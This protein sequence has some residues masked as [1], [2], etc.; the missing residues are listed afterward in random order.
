MN[1]MMDFTTAAA[2]QE[3][4]IVNTTQSLVR[5]VTVNYNPELVKEAPDGMMVPGEESKVVSYV[6][7]FFEKEGIR[8]Q[9][10]G[11]YPR[12]DIVAVIGRGEEGRKKLILPTHSDV[13]PS[14]NGWT[15]TRNPFFPFVKDGYI[16]GRGTTDNKGQMAACMAMAR[17]LKPY[18][19]QIAGQVIFAMVKGEENGNDNGLLRLVKSGNISAT[20]AIVPDVGEEMKHIISAEKEIVQIKITANGK[21]ANSSTPKEG[22]NAVTALGAYCYQL[23]KQGLDHSYDS[24]FS[25]GHTIN[26]G[27]LNG[28]SAANI[29]PAR[30]EA[31]LDIR[32]LPGTSLNH[33]IDQ[34]KSVAGQYEIAGIRFTYEPIVHMPAFTVE[35]DVDVIQTIQKYSRGTT[36]KGIGVRT[37]CGELQAAGINS[38]GWGPGE[39]KYFHAA[40][41]RI[42]IKQLVT[43]AGLGANIAMDLAN[44]KVE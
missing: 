9:K 28:G 15:V 8:S 17:M 14:G 11:Y 30:A 12:E 5:L 20:D 41:E 42:E 3:G 35:D 24:R 40:N 34:L 6:E 32:Y 43:F 13:V 18:E 44:Q 7:K 27:I 38:V 22:I 29:V 36:T 2:E 25:D 16:Y 1:K 39:S 21:Q 31:V 23:E 19:D 33:I 26:T 4:F 37:I 10:F